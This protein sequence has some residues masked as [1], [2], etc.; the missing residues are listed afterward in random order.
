MKKLFILTLASAVVIAGFL[1]ISSAG[2]YYHGHSGMKMSELSE[3]DTDND[4]VIS[5]EEFSAP[6]MERY[7]NAFDMLDSSQNGEIDQVEWTNFLEVHGYGEK[8]EG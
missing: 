5:F 1:G 3:M 2:H 8:S 7:K 4:G 6:H